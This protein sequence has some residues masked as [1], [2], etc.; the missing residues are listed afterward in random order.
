MPS[1]A[2]APPA[3]RECGLAAQEDVDA[4]GLEEGVTPERL[5]E[6][7]H[8]RADVGG[9]AEGL[10]ARGQPQGRAAEARPRG[11]GRGSTRCRGRGSGR[12]GRGRRR[13]PGARASSTRS[14]LPRPTS[15][16]SEAPG[17]TARS[18]RG[19]PVSRARA[20]TTSRTR[21]STASGRGP[22]APAASLSAIGVTLRG[23]RGTRK[24]RG[25]AAAI[26]RRPEKRK[27]AGAT[28]RAPRSGKVRPY[29]A[30]RTPSLAAL[31]T[32]NFSRFRAGILIASPVCGL[33]P[34]RA[35]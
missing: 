27:G 4:R 20:R 6:R 12:R 3:G 7:A 9:G 34:M 1:A 26:A 15:R 2:L 14:R 5:V 10:L 35:L 23:L 25:R 30:P 28:S 32:T 19:P 11:R 18:A 13:A 33:R 24:R 16:S 8:A 22:G 21:S 29:F 31:A 17:E